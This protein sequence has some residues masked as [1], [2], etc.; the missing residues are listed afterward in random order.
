MPR[1][2]ENDK[3]TRIRVVG[4]KYEGRTGWLHKN[5]DETDEKVYVILAAQRN[6]PEECKQIFKKSIE[7][8][9]KPEP[10]FWEQ[11]LMQHKKVSKHYKAF[12]TKLCEA[13]FKP[14][15]QALAV[16]WYD[17][18]DMYQSRQDQSR[19]SGFIRLKTSL[20]IPWHR[21]ENN[22]QSFGATFK[23]TYLQIKEQHGESEE[24][25]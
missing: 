6:K 22:T 5:L 7:F 23:Q 17:W 1:F 11:A 13:E 24:M 15:V 20:E 16:I 18:N 8:G 21:D 9:N 19:C 12:L 25:V 10:M 14:T 3:G 4:G 2:Q